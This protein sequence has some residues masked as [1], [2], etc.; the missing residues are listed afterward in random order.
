MRTRGGDSWRVFS[1][2]LNTT[3]SEN[4]LLENLCLHTRV[5][6]LAVD[7]RFR[8][9][10]NIQINIPDVSMRFTQNVYARILQI[11]RTQLAEV[12]RREEEKAASSAERLRKFNSSSSFSNLHR[13]TSSGTNLHQSTTSGISVSS[14]V[15]EEKSVASDESKPTS[16]RTSR[17]VQARREVQL[18]ALVR[19]VV[20]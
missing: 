6:V 20:E 12:K 7:D 2:H 17:G 8:P 19:N 11:Y 13:S 16:Y 1:E 3:S 9:N 5:D 4:I 14:S 10:F 18:E 15:D